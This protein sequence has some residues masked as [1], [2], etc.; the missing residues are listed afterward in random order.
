MSVQYSAEYRYKFGCIFG[1]INIR[2]NFDSCLTKHSFKELLLF[3]RVKIEYRVL[4]KL[5][6]M[7]SEELKPNLFSI[8]EVILEVEAS[9]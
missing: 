7:K 6:R 2:L 3:R 5:L 1:A 9:T 8:F 4:R